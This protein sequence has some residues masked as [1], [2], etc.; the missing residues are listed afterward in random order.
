VTGD[1][2]L[3]FGL[4][5]LLS[6]QE[7]PISPQYVYVTIDDSFP[8]GPEGCV[9][10]VTA[11]RQFC[12]STCSGLGN[13]PSLAHG[14]VDRRSSSVISST[15]SP[16]S[17]ARARTSSR[18][19]WVCAEKPQVWTLRAVQRGADEPWEKMEQLARRHGT[20]ASKLYAANR[21]SSKGME[22]DPLG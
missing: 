19:V 18:Q 2:Y 17:A 20:T 4:L 21:L 14:V 11:A 5:A 9:T 13:D 16:S 6:P 22:R 8:G 3:C 7:I 12:P 15:P 1:T 10:V